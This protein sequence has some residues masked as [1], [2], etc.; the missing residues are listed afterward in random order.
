MEEIR[1]MQST[2]AAF[3]IVT[4][5][6][7]MPLQN[8]G[9]ELTWQVHRVYKTLRKPCEDSEVT[10]LRIYESTQGEGYMKQL[11]LLMRAERS[12]AVSKPLQQ[13]DSHYL[14]VSAYHS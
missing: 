12:R 1:L 2:C 6:S 5:K 9:F 4:K 10:R 14:V 8:R 13:P 7:G 11:G 3:K